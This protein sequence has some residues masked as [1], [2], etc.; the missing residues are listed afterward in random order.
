LYVTQFSVTLSRMK[1]DVIQNTPTR[2]SVTGDGKFLAAFPTQADARAFVYLA[3]R[4]VAGAYW[5]KVLIAI[6]MCAAA[7]IFRDAD[8]TISSLTGLALRAE[9]PPIW[10]IVLGEWF[11]NRLQT[12]HCE[13][14]IV[15]DVLRLRAAERLLLP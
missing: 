3:G 11:L 13:L 7:V 10:A 8:V 12:D 9:T 4:I 1:F 6:D 14:A 2:W 5:F 15:H